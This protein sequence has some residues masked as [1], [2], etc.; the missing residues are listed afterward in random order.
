MMTRACP[1]INKLHEEPRR[2]AIKEF[3]E[4]H[5]PEKW[6]ERKKCNTKTIT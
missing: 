2:V 1:P 4:K 5:V 3:A 6:F